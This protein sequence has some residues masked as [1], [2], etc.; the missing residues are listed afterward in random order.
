MAGARQKDGQ[1]TRVGHRPAFDAL[2][3]KIEGP[4][5][6]TFVK[7]HL[8]WVVIVGDIFGGGMVVKHRDG[9]L[10]FL[11]QDG[12]CRYG[13]MG[14]DNGGTWIRIEKAE[15]VRDRLWSKQ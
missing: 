11:R 8:G 12:F 5:N 9:I 4:K 2:K 1:A 6:N 7:R 15:A 10:M 14:D 13:V 3:L